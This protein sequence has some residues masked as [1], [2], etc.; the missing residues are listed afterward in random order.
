MAGLLSE[1]KTE[2]DFVLMDSPPIIPLA[3]VNI[4]A[5]LIDGLLLVVRAGKT[6]KDMVL[7]AVNSLTGVNIAGIVLNGVDSS[8]KKYYYSYG[9]ES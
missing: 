6:P 5:K 8:P 1:L 4:L 3:D 7:K 9:G 2:F